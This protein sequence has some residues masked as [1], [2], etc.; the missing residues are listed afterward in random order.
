MQKQLYYVSLIFKVKLVNDQLVVLFGE[1]FL[2]FVTFSF[3]WQT[4]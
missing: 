3:L 2:L 4:L 1:H